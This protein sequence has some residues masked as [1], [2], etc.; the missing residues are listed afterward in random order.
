ME[1]LVDNE[2]WE[3]RNNEFLNGL[4]KNREEIQQIMEAT[5]EQRDSAVWVEERRKR[6]TASVFGKICKLRSTTDPKKVAQTMLKGFT[7]VSTTYGMDHEP[8][9]LKEFAEFLKIEIQPCGF[10][11]DENDFYLGATPDGLVGQNGLVEV[12]C[13][14]SCREL[15]PINAIETKK[16]TYMTPGQEEHFNLKKNHNYFYQVQGQLHVTQ[17]D[18]CYFVVWTPKGFIYDKIMRDDEF[19]YN[20]KEK[21]KT[22]YFNYY[23]PVILKLEYKIVR[24]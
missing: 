4:K 3:R 8:I 6:I 10:F 20:I 16:L 19:F 12:K 23:L 22:F 7:A 5:R 15:T 24:V 9:A 18:F 2:E 17:R 14:Y 21:L 1:D 13:P 11:V